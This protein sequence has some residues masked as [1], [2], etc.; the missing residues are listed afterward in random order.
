MSW[1]LKLLPFLRWFKGYSGSTLRADLIAGIT[2]ALVLV[3]Q[4]MA[5]AQL[6]G[7]PPYYGLYAAFLPGIVASLFGSSR[8]LATGP[9]AVVSLM[10][11]AALEPLASAGSEAF[12]GYALFLSLLVG[13]FQVAL[14]VLRLG[15][16]VNFLS[17][18]VVNGFTNA[19]ALII[20]TSQLSKLFGVS[21]AKAH[22]HLV[23]V[24]RVLVAGVQEAHLPTVGMAVLAFATMI[25]LRKLQP[26]IPN[27]LV[28]VVVA[29]LLAWAVG[30]EQKQTVDLSQ[31]QAPEVVAL[32]DRYNEE[33][34]VKERFEAVRAHGRKGW[35]PSSA[36]GEKACTACHG[37]R[38]PATFTDQ[39]KGPVDG[40]M[41]NA[42]A[43][44]E[45]AGVLEARSQ[46]HRHGLGSLRT[47][48]TRTNLVPVRGADG[49]LVFVAPGQVPP[50]V[51]PEKGRWH[52]RVSTG[53]LDTSALVLSGGGSVVGAIPRGLPTL[54]APSMNWSILGKLLAAA[55]IISLLGFMEAISIAKAMAARTRQHLDANQELV[56]QGL[57]NLVG[58]FTQGYP[59]SGSFSRTAVNYQAGGQT[60]LSNVVA[61]AMVGVVLL[62]LSG[63]LYHL[64]D[65]VLAAIIVMAVAGLINV[66]GFVHAWRTSRLDGAISIITFG[67]TLGLAPELEWGIA[68]GVSLSLIAYLYRSM[69]P[70]VVELVPDEQGV[71]RDVRRHELTRCKHL[72]VVG[73][74]GPLNFASVSYLEETL[75]HLVADYTGLKHLVIKGDGISEID[76]SGEETL[77]HVVENLRTA[78]TAVSF[79]GWP[80]GIVDVLRRSGLHQEI[81]AGHFFHTRAEALSA[82]YADVHEGTGETDCPFRRAMPPLVELSMHPDGTLRDALRHK[83]PRCRH[84]AALRFDADLTF[85]NT[86]YLEEET[87]ARIA[88]RSNLRHLVLV[89]HGVASMDTSAAKRLLGMIEKLHGEGIE[90][91]LSGLKDEVLDILSRDGGLTSLGRDHLYPTQAAAIAGVYARA[92]A[93]SSEEEC[94]FSEF[95]PRLRELSLY[96][97]GALREADQYHLRTCQVIAVLR[98]DGS[99]LLGNPRALTSEFIAWAKTRISVNTVLFTAQ[100]LTKIDD[101]SARNLLG[102]VEAV[103]EAGFRVA[104]VGVPDRVLAFLS[105]H[106]MADAIG[107]DN[108]YPDERTAVASVHQQA[109]SQSSEAECPLQQ[110]LPHVTE[111]ARHSDGSLRGCEHHGL[112]HC[113]HIV[114]IRFDGLLNFATIGLLEQEL[115][116]RLSQRTPSPRHVLIAGHTLANVDSEA[117]QDLLTLI[118]SL[119][120]EGVRVALSGLRDDVLE[121]LE[122]AAATSGGPLQDLF[123]T[124]EKALDA[125]HPEAHQGSTEQPCPLKEVVRAQP[126]PDA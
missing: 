116:R 79:S 50:G 114:A 43:L 46:A 66:K 22:L 92:H 119:R 54:R 82:I 58:A 71:M 120:G 14:G 86:A 83:L 110:L 97:D 85:A 10:T 28:A 4:S 64:P 57:A 121:V 41:V 112:A 63:A 11:A 13:L 78:G 74:E 1:V 3:P 69:R 93:G 94:P 49:R 70:E 60:G 35:D 104:L 20:A 55:I 125:L 48:L 81:G 23:T 40:A 16:V 117:A 32:V 75:L 88:D 111:L 107:L 24:A 99:L 62:F 51:T 109:H 103:R 98:F 106:G 8:Q 45:L 27:V 21:V 37:E 52:L 68:T 87:R 108:L 59:V 105:R 89:A 67:V 65:A 102:L 56:G 17:H 15:L 33:Q 72:A 5:Y 6:A 38:D 47:D 118:Q 61:G 126:Q 115:R 26:R 113:Q 95:A 19:A 90:V 42:F 91:S 30:F 84:I 53:P 36:E 29:T 31:I 18:P 2:V 73:F 76:A 34:S 123:P 39:A 9:V 12:V 7:M 122:R 101:S 44:H 96:S 80:E 25:L 124:Q 100:A 77:R